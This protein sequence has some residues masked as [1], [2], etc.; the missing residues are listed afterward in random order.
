L[1][2]TSIYTILV[3]IEGPLKIQNDALYVVVP[4][5]DILVTI[6]K[7]DNVVLRKDIAKLIKKK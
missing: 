1:L 7:D 3:R 2:L 5:K 4:D 6:D